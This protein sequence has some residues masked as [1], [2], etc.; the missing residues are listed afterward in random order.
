MTDNVHQVRPRLVLNVNLIALYGTSHKMLNLLM[1]FLQVF[2]APKAMFLMFRCL[3][4]IQDFKKSCEDY[5]HYIRRNIHLTQPIKR[6]NLLALMGRTSWLMTACGNQ[7]TTLQTQRLSP[8]PTK[9]RETQSAAATSEAQKLADRSHWIADRLNSDGSYMF[10]DDALA[11][12]IFATNAWR[13]YLPAAACDSFYSLP[14]FA[15]HVF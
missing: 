12:A 2:L 15:R 3:L 14:Y 1:A 13:L 4:V 9:A 6:A 11:S 7:V 8:R 5:V 10:V